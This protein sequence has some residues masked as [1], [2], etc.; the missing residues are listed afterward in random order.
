MGDTH[1]RRLKAVTQSY[2]ARA[3]EYADALGSVEKLAPAD[4]ALVT[5]WARGLGDTP[6]DQTVLDIGCGPGQW[7]QLLDASGVAVRGIDPV[8]EFVELARERYPDQAFALGSAQA[9]GAEEGSV[10]GVLC[11]YALIHGDAAELRD[12]LSEFRRILRAGGGLALGFFEGPAFEPFAHAITEA[13]FWPMAAL[14][15][16]VESGG[17]TVTHTEARSD[18][19]SRRH[20][21]LLAVRT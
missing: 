3:R 17:F 18:P 11:W 5:R 21:A 9:T 15:R 16:E 12:G 7:T 19:G 13:Y 1:P 8:G 14:V 20:G 2:G 10:D 6:S 4:I